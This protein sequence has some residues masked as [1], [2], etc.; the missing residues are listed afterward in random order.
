MKNNKI[1]V[2]YEKNYQ[3]RF[4]HLNEEMKSKYCEMVKQVTTNIAKYI[5]LQNQLNSNIK[6]ETNLRNSRKKQYK[7][8]SKTIKNGEHI[9]DFDDNK[10]IIDYFYNEKSNKLIVNN[11]YLYKKI[12]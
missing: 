9:N 3:K 6:N 8:I 2:I 1:D 12:F 10:L 11:L 7:K 5:K 4:L